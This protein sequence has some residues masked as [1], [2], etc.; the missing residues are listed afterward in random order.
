MTKSSIETL[1]ILYSLR[2]K[3]RNKS[4]AAKSSDKIRSLGKTSGPQISVR[5]I[6]AQCFK[7]SSCRY[8]LA[9]PSATI[10]TEIVWDNRASKWSYCSTV[11]TWYSKI[12][13]TLNPKPWTLDFFEVTTGEI[14]TGKLQV[15]GY[16]R[17]D[18]HCKSSPG[19]SLRWQKA[20]SFELW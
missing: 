17:Y 13:L 10:S 1:M 18:A 15:F 3:P 6:H 16:A 9:A 7:T 20:K 11:H 5:F 14:L 8:Q 19:I 4:A 12:S 2:V